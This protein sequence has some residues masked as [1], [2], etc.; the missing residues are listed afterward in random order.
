WVEQ[1]KKHMEE[2]QKAAADGYRKWEGEA[3]KRLSNMA[4]ATKHEV[5]ELRQR[6]DE[7]VRKVEALGQR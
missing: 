1:S 7:L 4:P 6:V 3:T 2:L 5:Q